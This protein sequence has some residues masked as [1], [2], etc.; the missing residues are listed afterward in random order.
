MPSETRNVSRRHL[1]RGKKKKI[2]I[3]F[4]R[5]P[6][7]ARIKKEVI[8]PTTIKTDMKGFSRRAEKA[9]KL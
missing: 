6:A 2:D 4:K 9:D 1:K 8:R 5:H 3:L 7:E